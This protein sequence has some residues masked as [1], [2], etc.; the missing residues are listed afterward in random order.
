MTDDKCDSARDKRDTRHSAGAHPSVRSLEASERHK[1]CKEMDQ[2]RRLP[3][4]DIVL[5]LHVMIS[6]RWLINTSRR[7][8]A[9]LDDLPLMLN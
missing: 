4:V 2:I 5:I 1:G 3:Q 9:Q 8:G 6:A 7:C